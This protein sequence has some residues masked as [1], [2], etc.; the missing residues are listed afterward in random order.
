MYAS[1]F[2]SLSFPVQLYMFLVLGIYSTPSLLRVNWGVTLCALWSRR[3][4]VFEKFCIWERHFDGVNWGSVYYCFY[5]E[6]EGM[7]RDGKT[8]SVMMVA[9][10]SAKWTA[11]DGTGRNG[12]DVGE[13]LL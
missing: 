10:S 1:C 12:T 8:K 5:G 9:S 2:F 3:F 7:Y 4:L 6:N 13:R 11:R